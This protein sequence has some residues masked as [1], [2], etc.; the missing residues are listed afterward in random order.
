VGSER[1]ARAEVG[2]PEL[3]TAETSDRRDTGRSRFSW[4]TAAVTIG[5]VGLLGSLLVAGPTSSS[6][7]Q[8]PPPS[9]PTSGG[10]ARESKSASAR[11]DGPVLGVAVGAVAISTDFDG[12]I[13][14]LD[15]DSGV[16]TR[17]SIR[18][19]AF[20][21][22]NGKLVV[23]T[24][25]GGWRTVDIPEYTL[26]DNLIGCGSYKPVGQ[27]G[28]DAFFFARPDPSG[29]GEVLI[30][31]GQGGVVAT[32]LAGVAT[33]AYATVSDDQVLIQAAD[34]QLVWIQTSSGEPRRYTDGELIESGP[35][36]VLW[37]DCAASTEC[38]VWLGT[39]ERARLNRYAIQS[40]N[41]QFQARINDLGTRA[42][43]FLE[44]DILR[45]VTLET[46][47]AR[48]VENPGID[49]ATATWSPD[50]LWLLDTLGTEVIAFNTING[51]TVRFDGIPGDVS[52]GWIALIEGEQ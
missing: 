46:G 18:T 49:W 22:V 13:T 29:A 24:G 38:E 23:Q 45:I 33:S 6:D 1:L 3:V 11:F 50:G 51:R 8:L 4:L 19:G 16:V 21:T 34:S 39:P 47:H 17:T 40:G 43:F 37:A 14:A 9:G 15:L 20:V 7:D 12:R 42:V 52:P 27:R 32:I 41:G 36:G 35:G 31:D 2:R 28:A 25:C 48:Q 5:I 26:G 30:A 10:R 44:D